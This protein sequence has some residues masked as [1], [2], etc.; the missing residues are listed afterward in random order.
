M[1]RRILPIGIEELVRQGRHNHD[2]WDWGSPHPVVRL[3][4]DG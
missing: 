2:R 4:F 1:Q 3:S